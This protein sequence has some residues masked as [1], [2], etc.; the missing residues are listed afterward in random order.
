ME[1]SEAR[2]D[3]ESSRSSSEGAIEN[4]DELEEDPRY[5]K[6]CIPKVN[7]DSKGSS[8]HNETFSSKSEPM[9]V[10]QENSPIPIDMHKF[11]SDTK[12]VKQM[13]VPSY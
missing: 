13:V 10:V 11:K 8:I 5:K 3:L 4:I 7:G 12:A 1:E 9:L 6:N 2:D